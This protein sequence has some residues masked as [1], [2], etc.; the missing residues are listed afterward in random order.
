MGANTN[1]EWAD[2]TFNPWVGCTA[3]SPACEHCYAETMMDKRLHVVK[4]GAGQPRKR[5]GDKNWREPLKWNADAAAKGVRYRVFCASL[6]DV[7]DNEVPDAWR[8]DLFRLIEATPNLDWLLLT[9]RI[10]NVD[11]LVDAAGSLMPEVLVWPKPNVWLGATI[12]NQ[13]EADRD[14]PKLLSAPAAKRFLSMEPL[15]G[16]VDLTALAGEIGVGLHSYDALR[17]RNI[18]HDDGHQWTQDWKRGIDWV[19]VGGESGN[20]AR[21]MHPDWVRLLRDQCDSAGVAFLFK[22]WG[23]WFTLAFNMSTGDPVFRQFQSKQQWINKPNWVNGGSCLD[24]DGRE[25]KIGKDFDACRFPVTIMHKVGK[26]SAGR[27]LDGRQWDQ[28]PK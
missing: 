12:C 15:L 17:G 16:P 1:I 13:A 27:S 28:L 20:S 10:G 19:I 11:K 5:T 26:S 6:A 21:P 3:V 8:V 14:I 23:E 25:L 4:W 22:Q 2:H 7:F 9:K 24:A 18:H